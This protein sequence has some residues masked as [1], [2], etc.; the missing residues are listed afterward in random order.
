M[1]ESRCN[2]CEECGICGGI[3]AVVFL[4]RCG[5]LQQ[6]YKKLQRRHFHKSTM[7]IFN[8]FIF[9]VT[10]IRVVIALIITKH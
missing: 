1:M 8:N 4:V 6:L 10:M 7:L 3:C 5:G 2:V 9:S